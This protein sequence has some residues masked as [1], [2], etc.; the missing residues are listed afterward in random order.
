MELNLRRFKVLIAVFLVLCIAAAAIVPT[1][2]YFVA[3]DTDEKQNN[4]FAFALIT[5][6]GY[7]DIK[8]KGAEIGRLSQIYYAVVLYTKL[9]APMLIMEYVVLLLLFVGLTFIVAVRKKEPPR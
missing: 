3:K 2:S 4:G 7:Q 9:N 1:T 5:D 6:L 8:V